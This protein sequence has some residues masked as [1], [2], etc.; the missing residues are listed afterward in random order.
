MLMAE[1]VPMI[2]VGQSYRLLSEPMKICE[3]LIINK[4]FR[5]GGNPLLSWQMAN[6]C[7][8]EDGNRNI[9]PIKEVERHSIDGAS[10]IFTGMSR[11]VAAE[12][13][14]DNNRYLGGDKIILNMDD[15]ENFAGDGAAL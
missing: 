4:N 6:V 9:R 15:L 10:A 1:G 11:V 13:I 2:E 12:R 3:G 14:N 5:H 7:V 8:K